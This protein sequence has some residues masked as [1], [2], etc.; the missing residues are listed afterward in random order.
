MG[1]GG[2]R[3]G[4]SARRSTGFARLCVQGSGLLRD[5]LV[6]LCW[7]QFSTHWLG[8]PV[9]LV[10]WRRF[11]SLIGGVLL[12]AIPGP[13]IG[14]FWRQFLDLLLDGWCW[15]RNFLVCYWSVSAGGHLRWLGGPSSI[16]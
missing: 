15:W 8:Q 14:W 16:G 6:W 1:G 9:I 3:G 13:P 4:G 10:G 12:A 5:W 11:W 7:R 2:K